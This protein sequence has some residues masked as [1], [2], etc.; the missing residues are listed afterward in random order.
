MTAL[1]SLSLYNNQLSGFIP[2]QLFGH[3]YNTL[4]LS[5]NDWTCPLPENAW[6][7]KADTTCTDPDPTAP[8]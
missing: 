2:E 7:D 6:T 8:L 5:G 1:V 3:T 4:T